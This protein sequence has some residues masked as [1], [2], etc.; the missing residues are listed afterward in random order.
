MPGVA[1]AE[2]S[3]PIPAGA[4]FGA[5]LTLTRPTALT[6][7]V[8]D[9][10]RFAQ[11]PILVRGRVSDVCQ[12]KGCWLM[13][14][15]GDAQVRVHFKDYGFFVPTDSTGDEVFVEGLVTVETLS[16]NA[17]RHYQSESRRGNPDRV[18]GPRRE[19]VFTAT[20]VRLVGRGGD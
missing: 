17:A 6:E 14:S 20:G 7:V 16:E 12:R 15:D 4:D 19:V 1:A 5:G 9:P 18:D 10:E 2:T 11:Q 8:G 3:A 13:L